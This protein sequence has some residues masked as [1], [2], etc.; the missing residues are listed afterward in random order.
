MRMVP[1]ETG[2]R[3][4]IARNTV[5]DCGNGGILVTAKDKA[6]TP[7]EQAKM[8]FAIPHATIHRVEDGHVACTN[9][10]I[11]PPLLDAC[12]EVGVA[13]HPGWHP[14]RRRRSRRTD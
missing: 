10:A 13:S 8:A 5:A 1:A 12:F 2:A 6:V 4:Q 9:P 11:V 7:G 14:E 3:P